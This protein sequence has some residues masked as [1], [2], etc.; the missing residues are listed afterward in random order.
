MLSIKQGVD[1]TGVQ[2][3]MTIA[4]LIVYGIF[5][6]HGSPSVITSGRDGHHRTNVHYLGYALDFRTRH[7]NPDSLPQI[8]SEIAAALG[9]QFDVVLEDDHLHVEFDP[10]M[11]A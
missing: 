7:M 10:G 5:D 3:E 1:L 4:S 8:Q 11:V 2:S 6:K 9:P